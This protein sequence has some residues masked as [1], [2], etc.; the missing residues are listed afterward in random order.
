MFGQPK[1]T[2]H[3]K[4]FASDDVVKDAVQ[5]QLQPNPKTFSVNGIRKLVNCHTICTEKQGHYVEK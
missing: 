5:M 1:A 2:L 4:I 3:G